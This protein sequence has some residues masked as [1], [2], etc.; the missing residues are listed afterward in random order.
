MASDTERTPLVG[1]SSTSVVVDVPSSS[2]VDV[3]F[4][5]DVDDLTPS[6]SYKRWPR[7]RG[8]SLILFFSLAL[9]IVGA[10]LFAV[11][12]SSSFTPSASAATPASAASARTIA[13]TP[14]IVASE[15]VESSTAGSTTTSARANAESE[16]STSL[17]ESTDSNALSW[18]ATLVEEEEETTTSVESANAGEDANAASDLD[19]DD[20]NASE[21]AQSGDNGSNGDA[22]V[23]NSSP[24]AVATVEVS[25]ATRHSFSGAEFAAGVIEACARRSTVIACASQRDVYGCAWIDGTCRVGCDAFDGA[26]GCSAQ[27]DVC[28][29]DADEGGCSYAPSDCDA[30]NAPVACTTAGSNK[31]GWLRD[32]CFDRNVV[33]R[34]CNARDEA[35]CVVMNEAVGGIPCMWHTPR[36][37]E[38]D[39]K[40]VFIGDAQNFENSNRTGLCVTAF[41]CAQHTNPNSCAMQSPACVYDYSTSSCVHVRAEHASHRLCST[42]NDELNACPDAS[43]GAK[44]FCNFNYEHSGFCQRCSSASSVDACL[45]LVVEAGQ[46]RCVSKCFTAKQVDAAP[47]A[48]PAKEVTAAPGAYPANST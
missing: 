45:E 11:E 40:V 2:S 36:T 29:F 26:I 42:A 37:L 16:S 7:S 32:Q 4:V 6:A 15:S 10:V 30:F 38:I 28:A 31:C 12:P 9:A 48:Y 43:D 35:S 34:G 22:F 21:G 23:E 8:V 19:R 13:T 41:P 39:G 14:A 5:D 46:R 18:E 44:T 24:V 17:S 3:R 47:D 25:L 33:M 27:G 20:A 1:P